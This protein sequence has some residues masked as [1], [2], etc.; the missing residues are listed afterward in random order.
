[1][2]TV[3]TAILLVVGL[4]LAGCMPVSTVTPLG[5]T[6][7]LG[8]DPALI[9]TWQGRDEKNGE[10]TI[11]LTHFIA[12][13]EHDLRLDY[14]GLNSGGA[15]LFVLRARTANLGDNRLINANVLAVGETAADENLR[16]KNIP[17]L[18]RIQG[19][20]LTLS[21]LD[22]EKVKA[23]IRAGRII[24]TIEPGDN[25]DV[26]ITSEATELDAFFATPEAAGMFTSTVVLTRVR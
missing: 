19:D 5:T 9:G 23:A 17:V 24:G 22:K 3:R 10:T 7:G 21:M 11:V 20:T 1:M 14:I 15:V 25:G 26:V 12:G 18:Y 16:N 13:P 6:V 2:R 4:L 8:A